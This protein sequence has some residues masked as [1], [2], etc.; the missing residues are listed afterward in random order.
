MNNIDK[1]IAEMNALGERIKKQALAVMKEEVWKSIRRNF[2]EGGRPEKW[3]PSNKIG[4]AA[5]RKHGNKT[6]ID[7]GALSNVSVEIEGDKVVA[8][9]SVEARHYARI[10]QEGGVINMPARKYKFRVKTYK[11]K[12]KR[13]VFA[14]GRHA[15]ITKETQGKAYSIRI[16][17]RPYLVIPD[18][19]EIIK[20]IKEGI[21]F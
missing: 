20:R 7:S 8:M 19:G 11:D 1:V 5:A 15:R 2:E 9:P 6:L 14:S 18:L 16:P 12:S 13:T 10:H 3:E 17:A 21:E 4:K